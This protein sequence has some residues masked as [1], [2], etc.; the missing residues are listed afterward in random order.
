LE[1]LHNIF[2]AA[3]SIKGTSRMLKLERINTAAHKLEDLLGA[4]RSGRLVLTRELSTLLFHGA[5]VIAE[6]VEENRNRQEPAF[7]LEAFC[8]RLEEALQGGTAIGQAIPTRTVSP[9]RDESDDTSSAHLAPPP[10]PASSQQAADAVIPSSSNR[11]TPQTRL[12]GTTI[13]IASDR[14]DEVINA[15]GEISLI[16]RRMM[17]RTADLKKLA[18]TTRRLQRHAQLMRKDGQTSIDELL[19]VQDLVAQVTL[20]ARQTSTAFADDAEMQTLLVKDLQNKALGMRMLP[21]STVFNSV[22]RS[23]RDIAAAVGKEIDF[24]SEGGESELDKKMIERIG[25]PLL[26]MVRN[27]IDHGIEPVDKRRQAGKPDRGSIRLFA[28]Y[29]GGSIIIELE[30]DGAGLPLEAVKERA[31]K[32]KLVDR[33]TLEQMAE[34]EVVELIFHPGLSTSSFI[35]DVSGRGVG[36]DVVRK[37]IVEELKGEITVETTPGKGSRFN[38]RLPATLAVRSLLVVEAERTLFAFLSDFVDEIIQVQ[39]PD[40]IP[41][42]GYTAVRLREQFIP[43]FELLHLLNQASPEDTVSR[44]IL[45]ILIVSN[46]AERLGIVVNT[47]ESQGAMTIKP[48][49]VHLQNNA[50]VSGI[51]QA[52]NQDAICLLH[53]PALV[54]RARQGQISQRRQARA[55]TGQQEQRKIRILVADDSINTSEIERSILESYGYKVEVANDG[56]SAWSKLQEA[57]YDLLITDIEMPRM[58]G[59]TLTEKVRGS[60][61]QGNLPVII[62][63]SLESEADKKRGMQVG[64]NAYIVKGDFQQTTLLDTVRTLVG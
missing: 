23:V 26:H 48:L 25:E 21:L 6:L 43:V 64:A 13:R 59:F 38:I 18:R 14:L 22:A 17:E 8:R 56:L 10:P 58:D 31:L 29:E 9:A 51:T 41:M 42:A 32:M 62:V 50:W 57:S 24:V 55:V 27:A 47:L 5:D 36:M 28:G 40:L 49:P 46:G 12:A 39:Q 35:T 7:D 16:Q 53:V 19:N 61:P 34:R 30:D 11:E 3:H 45:T 54:A 52:G 2:R 33:D 1:T 20:L 4:L 15:T 63:T 44:E 37:N 60:G